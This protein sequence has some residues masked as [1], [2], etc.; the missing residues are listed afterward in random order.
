MMATAGGLWIAA[1]VGG[2]LIGW[3][4]GLILFCIGCIPASCKLLQE[5]QAAKAAASWRKNYPSYKY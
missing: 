5:R 3:P 1:L 4:A 2:S